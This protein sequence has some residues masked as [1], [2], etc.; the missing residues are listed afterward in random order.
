[1]LE[2]QG[3]RRGDTAETTQGLASFTGSDSNEVGVEMETRVGVRV[4]GLDSTNRL[5]VTIPG[6]YVRRVM[7][8]TTLV[9]WSWRDGWVE[10]SANCVGFH[11][12]WM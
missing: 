3:G 11:F 7:V 2:E 9:T 5:S 6:W 10:L 4:A 1:M 8:L 12:A